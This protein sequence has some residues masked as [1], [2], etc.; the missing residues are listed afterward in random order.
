MLVRNAFGHNLNF[1]PRPPVAAI[2]NFTNVFVYATNFAGATSRIHP[3]SAGRD[4]YLFDSHR[5]AASDACGHQRNNKVV[6]LRDR[7]DD[8]YRTKRLK[9]FADA[10]S[11]ITRIAITAILN[12]KNACRFHE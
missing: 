1:A 8:F 7:F 5:S 9:D 4:R 10:L 3:V 6:F 11:L 2:R 12:G